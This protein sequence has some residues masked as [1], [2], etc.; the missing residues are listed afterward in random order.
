M[1]EIRSVLISGASIAGP[2]L[3]WWLR[4]HGFAPV[5][6][7]KAPGP[8][9]GGQAIDARGVALRVLRAMGL[10]EQAQARRTRMKGVSELDADGNELWRSEEFTISGGSFNLE[11]V[12]I[13]RDDLSAILLDALPGDVEVIYGDSIAALDETEDGVAVTFERGPA[14]SFD[15]VAGADG[16][17]STTRKLVFGPI[18]PFL[19]SFDFALALFSAPNTI[20][21]ED[22]QL[23]WKD[24]PGSCTVYTTP[25]NANLRVSFG[26]DATFQD[27]PADRAAQLAMVRERCGHMRWKAPELL[28]AMDRAS[29]FYLGSFAQVKMSPWSKGRVVLVGDAAYCPS[30]Y[31]GQ[32]TS[33]ALV[34]ACVLAR[35]LALSPDDHVAAF[36]RYEAK[37]RPFVETNQAIADLTIAGDV[38]DPE[39]YLNVIEPAMEAA[40]DAIEL[41]GLE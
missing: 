25:G 22:W 26:F 17:A 32:G 9:S 13:L 2:A 40:K 39:Y 14:R 12:E 37:M 8:R 19:R 28:D 18:E 16:L 5:L 34:G 36:V 27:V 31:T 21:L 6:V 4:H 1:P 15:L 23:T 35:E 11:T 10:A 29:D 33:L 20:G 7:E 3:A 24:G 38:S 30:P 41:E